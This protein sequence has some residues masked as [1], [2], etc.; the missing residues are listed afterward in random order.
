[1][2]ETQL[3]A[4]TKGERTRDAIR[5]AADACFREFGFAA[6]SA[7]IARRAGV[8]EGTVF[9]HYRNKMGLL[10]AVTKDF[11]DLLQAEAEDTLAVAGDPITR[12]R[13]LV[14]G[15]AARIES[16]WD[17]I[18]VFVQ[19]SQVEPD[20]ELARTMTTLNRRYTRLFTQLIDQLKEVG[21]LAADTPTPL[22]RDIL[23]GTLEHTARGEV[24]AGKEIRVRTV[25]QQT[26]DLL[27]RPD[28]PAPDDRL[29]RIEEKLDR[30]LDRR[31]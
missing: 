17:L 11:Y 13:R 3:D 19:R 27:V 12:L 4:Q 9:L 15:W 2:S 24:V 22:V 5:A 30:I 20:S 7:E 31:S 21:S 28:V 25:A 18:S 6:T 23:F 26:V 8:V 1:M 16:D 14:D 29:A 10:T